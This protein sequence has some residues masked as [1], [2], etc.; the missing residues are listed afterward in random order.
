MRQSR[1][2]GKGIVKHGAINNVYTLN[3]RRVSA[4]TEFYNGTKT[5][6]I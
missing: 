5:R 6:G 4:G 1:I 3:G 2:F